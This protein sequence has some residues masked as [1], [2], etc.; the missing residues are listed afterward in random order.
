MECP[1]PFID[2]SL[3]M[4]AAILGDNVKETLNKLFL[5]RIRPDRHERYQAL[6]VRPELA[7]ELNQYCLDRSIAWLRRQF[8]A[9]P[10]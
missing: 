3:P 5:Y 6:T 2:I 8:A 4:I 9:S 1:G 10:L 7:E